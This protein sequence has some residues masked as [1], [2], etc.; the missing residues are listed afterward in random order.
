M[1]N[2]AVCMHVDT[3]EGQLSEAVGNDPI[4]DKHNFGELDK[5]FS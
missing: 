1:I 2:L 4:S 3:V 5:G